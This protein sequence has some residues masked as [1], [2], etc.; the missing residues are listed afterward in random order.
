M[1]IRYLKRSAKGR[2]TG[3]QATESQPM[4]QECLAWVKALPEGA[5][6]V[7][8]DYPRSHHAADKAREVAVR[9]GFLVELPGRRY[10]RTGKKEG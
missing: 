9:D 7:R 4:V 10:V 2:G 8:A 5:R 6:P 3:G 1:T